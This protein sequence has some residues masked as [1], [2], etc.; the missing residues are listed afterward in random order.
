M[1][2]KRFCPLMMISVAIL[3]QQRRLATTADEAE[4]SMCIGED[5]QLWW[6]CSGNI[7][8]NV[9]ESDSVIQVGVTMEV[10]RYYG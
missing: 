1:S 8:H 10:E 7:V 5:C 3:S 2:K 9:D 4:A 6:L